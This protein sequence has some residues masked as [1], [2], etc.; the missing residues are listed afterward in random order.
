[1]VVVLVVDGVGEKLVHRFD[2][3]HASNIQRIFWACVMEP[4]L[5]CTVYFLR[6]QIRHGTVFRRSNRFRSSFETVRW[7]RL[8]CSSC[9]W[10][11]SWADDRFL[12]TL[13]RLSG[14]HHYPRLFELP[15]SIYFS[16]LGRK[17]LLFGSS[18]YPHRVMDP[19]LWLTASENR[20]VNS[21]EFTTF[22]LYGVD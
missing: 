12:P 6:E 7:S 10:R 22:F 21:A 3:S 19:G 9:C 5:F 1:M 16:F 11:W 8:W 17:F 4:T 20:L 18:E 14:V 13:L 15:I 2:Y